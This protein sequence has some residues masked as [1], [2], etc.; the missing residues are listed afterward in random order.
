MCWC[1][2]I[3]ETAEALAVGVWRRA[4]VGQPDV[5]PTSDAGRLIEYGL[6]R[7]DFM[8]KSRSPGNGR[9]THDWVEY[10]LEVEHMES[11]L[12]WP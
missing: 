8:I 5:R 10:D 2:V 7:G 6:I 3:G 12:K 11:G 1:V 9:S 4:D